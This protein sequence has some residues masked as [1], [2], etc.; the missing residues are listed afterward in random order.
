MILLV[1]AGIAYFTALS[2][3]FAQKSPVG[4]SVCKNN[5]NTFFSIVNL[6]YLAVDNPLIAF[7]VLSKNQVVIDTVIENLLDITGRYII[8]AKHP[9]HLRNHGL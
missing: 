6:F 1:S 7:P 5:H 3:C 2:C 8:V 4:L 9:H